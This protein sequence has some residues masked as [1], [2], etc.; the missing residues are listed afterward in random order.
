MVERLTKEAA[1]TAYDFD[2]TM[3]VAPG[4]TLDAPIALGLHWPPLSDKLQKYS[5]M[6]DMMFSLCLQWLAKK[7]K[8][9]THGT[10]SLA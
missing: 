5:T 1:R 7:E 2:P 9:F 6:R 4:G 3:L 10:V 8:F